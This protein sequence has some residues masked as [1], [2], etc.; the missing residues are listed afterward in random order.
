MGEVY[1]LI[2]LC[3]FASNMVLTKVASG[4]VNI[5]I[6]FTLAT[7]MNVAFSLL[8]LGLQTA[9]RAD[10][11]HWHWDGFLVFA[12]AGIFTTY[13]GRFFFFTAVVR[14]GPARASVFQ[15]TGPI[16][17]VL[18]AWAALGERLSVTDYAGIAITLA[19]L[20]LIVFVPGAATS[21]ATASAEHRGVLGRLAAS[22]LFV[23]LG[24]SLCYATGNV[25]RGVAM[26]RWDEPILG[27][28][29]AA[30]SALLMILLTRRQAWHIARDVRASDRKGVLMY[31]GGGVLTICAQIMVFFSIRHTAVSIATLISSCAP[32]IVIPMSY[33]LL[34]NTDKIN[35]RI[36]VGALLSMT[37]VALVLI[38]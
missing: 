11:L 14:F 4:R 9:L 25:L 13:L 37:G 34:G 7:G 31:L 22:I 8:L 6:G 16:F 26:A 3:L 33:W 15:V 20:C 28:V 24:A 10:A 35:G 5:N 12:L 30:G 1:A 23:G 32:V 18:I 29:I 19:G 21:R 2:A 36:I 38:G 27:S 17:T